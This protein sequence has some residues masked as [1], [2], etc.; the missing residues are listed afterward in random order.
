MSNGTVVLVPIETSWVTEL[1]FVSKPKMR[2]LAVAVCVAPPDV[3]TAVM[4]KAPP[5]FAAGWKR[6]RYAPRASVVAVRVRMV[7]LSET[8][9]FTGI[10][11]IPAPPLADSRPLIC[12]GWPRW[13]TVWSVVR[14]RDVAGGNGG[15]VPFPAIVTNV[16]EVNALLVMV[17]VPLEEIVPKGAKMTSNEAVAE[18]A[19]TR[20]RDC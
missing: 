18:G 19:R 8:W 6:V 3:A 20:G 12:T 14:L 15:G 2:R 10:P 5:S 9:T 16:G 13:Y 1:G 7:P 11:E 4:V 17:M